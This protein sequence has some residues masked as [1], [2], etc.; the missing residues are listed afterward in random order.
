MF[1]FNFPPYREI[2]KT[3]GGRVH[4]TAKIRLEAK[5]ASE[6]AHMDELSY[7]MELMDVIHAAETALREFDFELLDHA[8]DMVIRKNRNRRYYREE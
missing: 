1:T 7:V 5:E 2:P 6:A 4:Q 3:R 8:K